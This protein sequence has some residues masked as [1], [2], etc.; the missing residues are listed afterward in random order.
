MLMS[1]MDSTHSIP[2]GE[3]SRK[4]EGFMLELQGGQ[5]LSLAFMNPDIVVGLVYEHT[6]IEPM[7]VQKMDEINTLLVFAEG[8]NIEK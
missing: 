6:T 5:P 4:V 8:E 1:L 7:V 3:S 2:I